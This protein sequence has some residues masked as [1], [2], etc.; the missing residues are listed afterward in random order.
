[1]A[2]RE[3][4]ER[5]PAESAL[6]SH[7]EERWRLFVENFDSE[8]ATTTIST[9]LRDKV[10]SG[11]A[12]RAIGKGQEGREVFELLQNARDAI[13]DGGGS[14]RAYVGIYD[15]GILVANT[16]APFDMF[17]PE[18]EEAV[19]MIGESSKDEAD[20]EIGH[21][22]VGLKSI[23][24]SGEAFEIWTRHEQ[25]A[26]D[27]LRIRL[28][29][30][31]LT[32]ALLAAMGCKQLER[33]SYGEINSSEIDR[34][35]TAESNC[36]RKSLADKTR[37]ELGKLPLFDFPVPLTTKT[38]GRNPVAEKA[39]SLLSG[40]SE[41]WY[42]EPY[43]TAVFVE[44][45]DED[46][47]RLR[48]AF[49]IPHPDPLTREPNERAQRLWSHLSQRGVKDGL[50]PE[51]LVQLG[52]IDTLSA[53]RVSDGERTRERWDVERNPGSI[54]G[55]TFRH[56]AVSVTITTDGDPYRTDRFDQF[57]AT[58]ED[59][60]VQLLIP[61]EL[62]DDGQ[63]KKYPL[64]MYYPIDNTRDV[65]LPFC[66][67]GHFTVNTNR[68]D[69]SQN[70]LAENQAVLENGVALVGE[71]SET[72]ADQG[73]GD[74][75][76]WILLP[77]PVSD[78]PTEPTT[79]PSLLRWLRGELIAELKTRSC[80][81]VVASDREQR[82]V[83][84]NNALLH[85]NT[86]IRD[87]FLSL[88]TVTE[89]ETD[90]TQNRPALTEAKMLTHSALEGWRTLP[91]TWSPRVKAVIDPTEEEEFAAD[92]AKSWATLLNRQLT[93]AHIREEKISHL[94]CDAG[95]ARSLFRG[96]VELVVESGQ[97]DDQLVERLQVL[98]SDL[99]GV[100]LLP[101]QYLMEAL[102]EEKTAK[103]D[104]NTSGQEESLLLAPVESRLNPDGSRRQ[105]P[106]TRSVFWD[107]E[108]PD[109]ELP[110]PDVPPE[111]SSFTV[112]L[113]D[114][115]MEQ[116]ERAR[117]IL[118]LAGDWWGIR[119]YDGV[120]NYF[121]E[122]LDTF[123]KSASTK[124]KAN[125]FYFL[126]SEISKLG[127]RSDDLQTKEGSF[128][129]LAYV[130]S[131]V[132]QSDGD[133][134]TNITRRLSLRENV[135]ALPPDW[136]TYTV[137]DHALSEAWQK[138]LS[139][140]TSD[141]E[142]ATGV[143]SNQNNKPDWP[144]WPDPDDESIAP[145]AEGIEDGD[146]TAQIAHTLS[147]LGAM[148]LPKIQSLWMYGPNHPEPQDKPPWNP[149]EWESEDYRNIATVP[150]STQ[151]IQR[152]LKEQEEGYLDWIT[153][154][155]FHPGDTAE[156]SS[157]CDVKT[158]L[159]LGDV[160]LATW[161]WADD[162]ELLASNRSNLRTRLLRYQDEYVN[163][164]LRT[165]WTCSEGHQP[166]GYSWEEPV[167]TLLNWQLRTLSI[168]DSEVEKHPDLESYWVTEAD[169]LAYTVATGGKRGPRAWR[170]FPHIDYEE[171]AVSEEFLRTL[172]VRPIEEFNA[173]EAA[174][175]FQRLL[176]VLA[177]NPLNDTWVPLQIPSGRS[178]DW[179]AAY[180]ALLNHILH[181]LPDEEPDLDNIPFLTH[182]PIQQHGEWR[183]ASLDW[184]ENNADK[185]R[186]YEDQSPKPWERRA[187]E[188][189][190]ERW[191][192]PQTAS[193]PFSRLP[194]ALGIEP[195]DAEKPVA[196]PREL[197][198]VAASTDELQSELRDRTPLIAAVVKR[199]GDQDIRSFI[200][201]LETAIDELRV[202]ETI[203]TSDVTTESDT[204]RE[205]GLFAPHDETEAILVSESAYQGDKTLEKCANAVS[206]LAEQPT[207]ISIFREALDDNLSPDELRD[208]WEHR[209]FPIE[210]VEQILGT[211]HRRHLRQKLSAL[212]TLAERVNGEIE[213]DVA[214]VLDAIEA[215]KGDEQSEVASETI[216]AEIND[217][218]VA[219]FETELRDTL[220]TAVHGILDKV[221]TDENRSWHEVL[222]DCN[223]ERNL[224]E[225]V[226]EWLDEHAR[227]LGAT[228][229][230]PQ[231]V[232]SY[233]PRVLAVLNAWHK[234]DP[235]ELLD[236][237]TWDT[238]LRGLS[239]D[240]EIT[241]VH[242]LPEK[243]PTTDLNGNLLFYSTR[244]LGYEKNVLEPLLSEIT[245]E[246]EEGQAAALQT[247]LEQFI[248]NNKLP[249]DDSSTSAAAHQA[250][251]F[252]DL[253]S[254]ED[255]VV[256]DEFI[257]EEFE[258]QSAEARSTSSGGG[259]ST[260]YRGRGQQGEAAVL[261]AILDESANWLAEQPKGTIRQFRIDFK[262][263]RGESKHYDWHLDRVWEE[264]FEEDILAPGGLSRES[265]VDWRSQLAVGR[266][267]HELPLV[268]LCNVALEQGP[269]FDVI[270][271]FGPLASDRNRPDQFVPVEVKT[272]NGASSPYHFRFTTNEFRQ[273]LNF[274]REDQTY[275]IRLVYVPDADRV[276]WINETRFVAETV[277]E[278]ESEA[279]DLITGDPLDELVKG[280]YLNLTAGQDG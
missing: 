83:A 133:Q 219:A 77:A 143:E 195:V 269:G 79:Q 226:I 237:E 278:S 2:S 97:E 218:V 105:Q 24:A 111:Q 155:G 36:E 72:V 241:W 51:T 27:I 246:F 251:A 244:G 166:E 233:H 71:V 234:T 42:G 52:E 157:A 160:V 100:F 92:I 232:L 148:S 193:G 264:E 136:E 206:L 227:A 198:Y 104:G 134:R 165:G 18:V 222:A 270:D 26:N 231:A 63:P 248:R 154:P 40:D 15:S 228:S 130:K 211:R 90:V 153:G 118:D 84:P 145:L 141:D 147:L 204:A 250:E 135:V 259:G 68:K 223:M 235:K 239:I 238:R 48:E 34:L 140:T 162:L 212:V 275:V 8:M 265:I 184:I 4:G 45:E 171:V 260:Q 272:V 152:R 57:S 70:S 54:Q 59:D 191:L 201:K 262:Q 87:G 214:D 31:Y 274:V 224:E 7:W 207:E 169:T 108:S 38:E 245:D 252:S 9:Q 67:H 96:T 216:F 117:R 12:E 21:K 85:W 14:G 179:N 187:V 159:I 190:D 109:S 273:C 125:D 279:R 181:F 64:Y 11:N 200:E 230:F 194:K 271:P 53:E 156:H 115:E 5:F 182:L 254:Y 177:V 173:T 146:G 149:T 249:T 75:Y 98:S 50:Q 137:S 103:T 168:W 29:R 10:K 175:H 114:Q 37:E 58:G 41:S 110:S 164:I 88:Y 74:R 28:S 6:F 120:P 47:Q 43:K 39:Q 30:A 208:R 86:K 215:E 276:D 197:T 209:T 93:N 144:E 220:P 188:Q 236:L 46:W 185:G 217:S 13:R 121:R 60:S 20:E 176:E 106:S 69:L 151:R 150:E 32:Q 266:S 172:G 256:V 113:F 261:T 22:G 170:L 277:I 129:P 183:I 33:E 80:I 123:T 94:Q 178:N 213:T 89:R 119:A 253:E 196:D 126:A 16:G 91:D 257:A 280:G 124:I 203:P 107:V 95:A 1:M 116:D 76:P 229:C 102:D 242:P 267:L 247:M 263:L 268:K 158:E 225:T 189:H 44:F 131:A 221:L 35:I 167:P 78:T 25:A 49:N 128:L 101:C 180:T 61:S 66:L 199:S 192:L 186:Y 81:P 163:S 82:A 19:T 65:E 138:V 202:A 3:A 255:E 243:L 112:Y 174:W 240:T 73:F 132:E 142:D 139:D 205:S 23:L 161:V 99:D 62:P 210:E 127:T 258:I 17:D 122:L 55:T 56:D